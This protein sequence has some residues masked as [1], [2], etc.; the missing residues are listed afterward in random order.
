MAT[1]SHELRTPL[2]ALTG[3]GEL[4]AEEIVGPLTVQQSD[5]VERMRSV[6]HHLGVVIDEI[7]TFSNLEAGREIVRPVPV[8]LPGLVRSA[9]AVVEP[10]ARIK[11]IAI[12]A[13]VPDG[14]AMVTDPDKVRQILVNLVGNAIKF[15]DA[16]AV[17]L[18]VGRRSDRIAFRVTDTGIGIR[19][20]DRARLFQAF[21]Q[22]DSGLTRKHGGT[23]L[24]LFISQRLAALLAGTIELESELGKGSTFTLFLPLQSSPKA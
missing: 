7:L 19:A 8:D 17:A 23:G 22:L 6:T 18:S 9:L 12:S 10:M 14:L 11:G 2:T 24:G 21:T 15:T 5:V 3:Y 16:G 1:M 4:L 13:D 20:A